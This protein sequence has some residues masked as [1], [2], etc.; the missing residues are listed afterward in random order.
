MA[1]VDCKYYYYHDGQ[2][3][4]EIRSG[5]DV[6]LKQLVW[7]R[8]YIDELVQVGVSQELLYCPADEN[9]CERF[10]WA[11]RDAN[12]NVLGL[13]SSLPDGGCS[14]STTSTA[15][16]GTGRPSATAGWGR[17]EQRR[18]RSTRRTA[19]C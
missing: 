14:L 3:I 9:R 18:G 11:C 12:W 7:G 16:T 1:D 15:L 4:V 6:A 8:Q 5:S 13:L 19:P 2:S 10:F 17:R